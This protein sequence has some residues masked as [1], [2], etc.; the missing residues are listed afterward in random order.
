MRN[1]KKMKNP[2]LISGYES[3]SYFCDRR[4]E[5]K[6]IISAIDNNRNLTLFSQ[7]RLGK[8][9]LLYHVFHILKGRKD[10]NLIYIDV[11]PTKNMHEFI[12]EFAKGVFFPRNKKS[13]GILEGIG[14]MFKSVR[15]SITYDPL[16]GAPIINFNFSDSAEAYNSLDTIFS[17]LSKSKTKNV[18]VID[19]FQQITNY[20]ETGVEA[21][22]RSHIQ[23]LKNSV[24]I[25]SGSR[26][27]LLLSM[28]GEYNRPFYQSSELM[29]LDKINAAEYKKFIIR[30]FQS[31][32]LNIDEEAVDFIL[33]WTKLHTYYVQYVC[34]K[35]F[36]FG[37]KNANLED[38]KYQCNLIL[39]DHE[40]LFLNY[41]NL[42]SDFQWELLKGIALENG[43]RKIT[44][45][46]FIQKYGL[47]SASSVQ[48]GI[49]AL[50]SKELIEIDDDNRYFLQD[51]FFSNWFLSKFNNK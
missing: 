44:S 19:E 35:V 49:K 15:P 16:T 37:Y 17:Y 40:P 28:F 2:F 10:I 33:F 23:K 27:R 50:L 41:R 22:L 21:L 3:P 18:I 4:S 11:Y 20:P 12:N 32:S 24:F 45:K 39:T 13:K 6:R 34:N 36:S 14:K 1:N 51:I 9:G 46:D 48:R 47:G 7:R 43:A 8:T 5:T 38:V 42:L 31:A 29:K 25:F 26:K 30:K